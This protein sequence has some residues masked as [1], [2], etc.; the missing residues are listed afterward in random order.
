MKRYCKVESARLNLY[1]CETTVKIKI[2]GF[3]RVP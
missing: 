2:N 3:L 1:R